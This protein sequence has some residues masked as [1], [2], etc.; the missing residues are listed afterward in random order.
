VHPVFAA[1]LVIFCIIVLI[2][3]VLMQRIFTLW[4]MARM[5]NVDVGFMRILGMR[6]RK[7]NARLI[8][9]A[10]IHASQG[11]VKEIT[12]D[13]LEAHSLAGGHVLETVQAVVAAKKAGVSLDWATAAALD[14]SGRDVLA[15]VQEI[16]DQKFREKTSSRK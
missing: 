6:F 11:G 3:L 9:K 12:L 10:M 14:L 1:M 13:M 16:T 2:Q 5:A 7:L 4:L 15:A 8:V